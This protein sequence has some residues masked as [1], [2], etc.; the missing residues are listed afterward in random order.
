MPSSSSISFNVST[1]ECIPSDT[2]AELPVTPAAIN[3]VAAISKLAASA[4]YN[5]NLDEA[6]SGMLQKACL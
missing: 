5:G 1:I 3:L 4:L 2:I 6:I